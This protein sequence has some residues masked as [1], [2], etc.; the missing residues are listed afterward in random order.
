M[1]EYQALLMVDTYQILNCSVGIGIGM[2]SIALDN[3]LGGRGIDYGSKEQSYNNDSSGNEAFGASM[4]VENNM[5][6][7]FFTLKF[8]QH[9]WQISDNLRIISVK[10]TKTRKIS[11]IHIFNHLLIDILKNKIIF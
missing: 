3:Q 1:Q 10:V 2:K 5:F 4:F 6:D 11:I 7:M 9:V 8:N